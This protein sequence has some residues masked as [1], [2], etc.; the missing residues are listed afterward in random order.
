MPF[1]R[2][3][4]GKSTAG[5]QLVLSCTAACLFIVCLPLWGGVSPSHLTQ[6]LPV[7]VSTPTPFSPRD[8]STDFLTQFLLGSANRDP[9]RRSPGWRKRGPVFFS[10]FK[11]LCSFLSVLVLRDGFLWIQRTFLPFYLQTQF[12]PPYP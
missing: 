2:T 1:E 7:C 9:E 11:W 5:S 4:R 8:G 10:S 3:Q 12:C 6:S